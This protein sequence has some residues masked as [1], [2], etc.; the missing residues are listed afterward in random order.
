MIQQPQFAAS[1]WSRHFVCA[2]D[3]R[4]SYK[5]GENV[6]KELPVPVHPLLYADSS[7]KEG[8]GGV[9]TPFVVEK[10]AEMLL[11]SFPDPHV[12]PPERGCT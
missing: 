8:I 2:L 6:K 1:L 11:V 10:W 7:F 4:R 12:H 5:N 9:A 3:L